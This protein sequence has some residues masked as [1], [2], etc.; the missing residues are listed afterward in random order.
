MQ[1]GGDDLSHPVVNELR[2][3]E[4]RRRPDNPGELWRNADPAATGETG[5]GPLA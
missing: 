5:G 3:R 1:A 2:A 4:G